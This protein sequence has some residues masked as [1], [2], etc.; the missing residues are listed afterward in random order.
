MRE[1]GSNRI[2][3]SFEEIISDAFSRVRQG[4]SYADL[5]KD[6]ADALLEIH[7]IIDNLVE[8]L[9]E[10]KQAVKDLSMG[11]AALRKELDETKDELQRAQTVAIHLTERHL[12]QTRGVSSAAKEHLPALARGGNWE[13]DLKERHAIVALLHALVNDRLL[14]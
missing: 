13:F 6:Q 5:P 4:K 12:A 11:S 3:P 10:R 7:A 2:L 14:P 9:K 1:A 8:Q